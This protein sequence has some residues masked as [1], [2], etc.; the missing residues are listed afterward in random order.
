MKIKEEEGETEIEKL[1]N[2]ISNGVR[3]VWMEITKPLPSYAMIDRRKVKIYHPGQRRTC[4]RCHQAADN[5]RGNSNAKLCEDNGGEKI[6]VAEAWKNTLD[7]VNYIEWNGGEIEI[8]GEIDDEKVNNDE[9]IPLNITNCDGFILSNLEENATVDEIKTIIKGAAPEDVIENISMH[10]TG[11]TRSKIIKDI[12]IA[13]VHQITKR[14]NQRSYKGRLVHCRPHVPLT[15]PKKE[16]CEKPGDKRDS[17]VK[18]KEGLKLCVTNP[19][20]IPGLPKE[21]MEKAIK[22]KDTKKRK[23]KKKKAEEQN[24][25]M[26]LNSTTISEDLSKEFDFNQA[27]SDTD[28][29][30]FQDSRENLDEVEDSKTKK[31]DTTKKAKTKSGAFPSKR[32]ASFA[33]LSPIE[34]DGKKKSRCDSSK[35]VHDRK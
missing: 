9:E 1:L 7:S 6:N 30:A 5:C 3:Q 14:V 32:G 21:E 2:N 15:P 16:V 8:V 19:S 18:E 17:S 23:E 25:V 34:P 11:S 22:K 28:D 27:N 24:E 20:T 33:H 12:D 4:A 35:S 29:D 31:L 10:P 26:N 13:Y